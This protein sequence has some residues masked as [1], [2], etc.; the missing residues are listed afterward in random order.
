MIIFLYGLDDYRREQRKKF[1]I[2]EF[3][4]KYSGLSVGY[5][6]L[7]DGSAS[8]VAG[9][10][11]D[12]LRAFLRGQSLFEKKKLAVIYGLFAADEEAA[13]KVLGSPRENGTVVLFSEAKKPPKALAFLLA[14]PT[15][16]GSGQATAVEEFEY[17]EGAGWTAFIKK[18]A[19]TRGVAL[20]PEAVEFLADIYIKNA[21]GLITELDKLSNL[22]KA[23]ISRAD[24]EALGLETMPNYWT[25]I[26]SAKS[27]NLNTRLW[28]LE[29]LF[30][31]KEPPAKLFN[32][33][34]SLWKEKTPQMAEQDFMVK[35]GK[36]EYEEALVGLVL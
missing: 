6:D 10:A 35:S 30:A 29:K 17:L 21:W 19:M 25:M 27:H 1:Y 24:L 5:F 4:K 11:L 9:S 26:N 34:A 32:I 12:D 36:L 20:S 13:K 3:K 31:Q 15:R 8:L 33:L 22:G 28:A 14:K 16:R 23:D 7:A 18:E 2:E